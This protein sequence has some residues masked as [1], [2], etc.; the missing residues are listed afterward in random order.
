MVVCSTM[1][2]VLK[3]ILYILFVYSHNMTQQ[4][5][6]KENSTKCLKC[7]VYSLTMLLPLGTVY[8]EINKHHLL[9]LRFVPSGCDDVH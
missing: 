9:L 6:L 3:I 2:I 7:F 5:N 1:C 4:L 8:T